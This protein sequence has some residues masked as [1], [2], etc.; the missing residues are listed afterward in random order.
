MIRSWE[1]SLPPTTDLWE[2]RPSNRA[3]QFHYDR[4]AAEARYCAADHT[5]GVLDLACRKVLVREADRD[6]R[7]ER[8]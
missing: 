8:R 4:A 7:R 1:S 3:L 2:I 6:V 5:P